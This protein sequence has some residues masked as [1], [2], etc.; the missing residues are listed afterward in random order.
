VFSC[1]FCN[2]D[3]SLWR[4]NRLFIEKKE[5]SMNI[6]VFCSANADIDPD[7]FRLTRELGQMIAQ[8][9]HT[10]VFGGCSMG[11]MDEVATAVHADDGHIIGVVPTI[12]ERGGK[13]SD[14]LD[15]MI[16]CDNLSDRKDF[17]IERSDILIALPGG[18]GTLDEIFTVLA[19]ASIG[20]HDKRVILYDMK[21]F[22]QP[23]LRLLDAIKAQG[24]L[25][26]GFDKHLLVA[27]NIDEI[28]H[29]LS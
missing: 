7:F 22:W 13:V 20:Y 27:K 9:G 12:I 4:E 1:L 5:K 28:E 19:A 10:L 11:L 26:S 17:I 25:R 16:M 6:G 18:V 29:F 2:K 14:C 3:V 21:G 23:L 15:E 24:M 8:K